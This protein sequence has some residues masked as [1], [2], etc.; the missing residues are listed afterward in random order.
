MASF[1]TDDRREK[2]RA[3]AARVRRS[4]KPAFR[5]MSAQEIMEF[6]RGESTPAPREGRGK[7]RQPD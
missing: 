5:R 3:A 6:L 7:K 2:L 4:M 1:V